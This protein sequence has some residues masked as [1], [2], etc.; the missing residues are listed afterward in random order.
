MLAGASFDPCIHRVASLETVPYIGE[1]DE[2]YC[3]FFFASGPVCFE[4]KPANKS[5]INIIIDINITQLI[6]AKSNTGKNDDCVVCV[7]PAV[8]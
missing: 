4:T 6:I 1:P 3:P 2:N 7:Y 8:R 5:N